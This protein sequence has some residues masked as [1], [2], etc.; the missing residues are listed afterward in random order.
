MDIFRNY[1]FYPGGEGNLFRQSN[2]EH[3]FLSF[4]TNSVTQFS[5]YF[6]LF[7]EVLRKNF[8]ILLIPCKSTFNLPFVIPMILNGPSSNCCLLI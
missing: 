6:F 8:K 5:N 2:L 3:I 4:T 7:L 1:T